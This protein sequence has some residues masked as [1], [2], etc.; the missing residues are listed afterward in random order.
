MVIKISYSFYLL[1]T[2]TETLIEKLSW[3][4][5]N[6]LCRVIKKEEWPL[7][8]LWIAELNHWMPLADI[9]TE[10]LKRSDGLYKTPSYPT[11]GLDGQ[12]LQHQLVQ[13]PEN[14]RENIRYEAELPVTVD[15]AGS[16]INTM[17]SDISLG[18]MRFLNPIPS[19]KRINQFFVYYNSGDGMLEFKVSPIYEKEEN[20]FFHRVQFISCNDFTRWKIVLKRM[21]KNQNQP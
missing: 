18:G 7:Y 21:E 9:V 16:L 20:L 19:R 8:H 5:L 10:I 15:I 11:K 3:V 17:T 4:Q 12:E 2:P 6:A 14:L 1:H 13:S